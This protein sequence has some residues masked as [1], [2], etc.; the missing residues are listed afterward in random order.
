MH[1]HTRAT[2]AYTSKEKE[3]EREREKKKK[4]T[5]TT[6]RPLSW[7]PPRAAARWS[8][9]PWPGVPAQTRSG[10]GSAR[11][12][13]KDRKADAQI[14]CLWNTCIPMYLCIYVFTFFIICISSYLC[15]C[16]YTYTFLYT[17]MYIYICIYTC[18]MH[19]Y[20]Y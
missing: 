15:I 10:F 12:H 16:A 1:I 9:G 18:C 19:I 4:I 8:R 11:G 3:R 14:E 5:W 20:V 6:Y 17:Y 2:Y 13:C 7:A